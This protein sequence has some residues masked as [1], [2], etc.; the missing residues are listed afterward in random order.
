MLTD[1]LSGGKY[2]SPTEKLIQQCKSVTEKLIQQCKSV[3]NINVEAEHD[4]GM[5]DHLKS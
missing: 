5:L 1:H 2:D 3:P 4:F